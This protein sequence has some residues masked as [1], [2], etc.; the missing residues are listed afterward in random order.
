VKHRKSPGTAAQA[1]IPNIDRSMYAC[2]YSIIGKITEF[3][4]VCNVL[5]IQQSRGYIDLGNNQHQQPDNCALQG[6]P[7]HHASLY[8]VLVSE[9]AHSD[10]P[11]VGKKSF[12]GCYL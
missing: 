12:A 9:L 5:G 7:L 1:T 2:N 6:L 4:S 8:V 10:E 3:A 11:F